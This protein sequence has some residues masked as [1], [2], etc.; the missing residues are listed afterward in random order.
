[1][2][3]HAAG[4]RMPGIAR[5]F[6]VIAALTLWVFA[7]LGCA[8]RHQ[9]LDGR[10]TAA[11]L[12]A[13]AGFSARSITA[14]GFVLKAFARS[15]PDTT[16][17]VYIEG[18]GNS[19]LNR[20]TPSKDPTP[21]LPLAF[22]LAAADPSGNVFYLARPCQF[23]SPRELAAC[24]ARYWTSDRYASDVVEAL[25]LAVDE[26]KRETG[27]KSV[28]LAGFSGGG[29]LAALLAASRNDVEGFMTL[30]GNLDTAA[31]TGLHGLTPLSGS[32]NPA[33][34]AG[35]LRG[36]PQTHI[37]GEKDAVCPRRVAE[38][39]LR[40]LG[41]DSSARLV[42]EPGL[43]HADEAWAARWPQLLR[44]YAPWRAD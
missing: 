8:G 37:V 1:M 41:P 6:A 20:V 16:L 26:A 27:A 21:K 28:R 12:A 7:S 29:T 25:S 17:T 23:L 19:W 38:S 14:G 32:L 11:A 33:D 13:T 42:V 43:G 24:P 2:K 44:D 10:E 3:I 34:E 22:M 39:Y 35:Y 30:G 40:R 36:V 15:S 4:G 18:D 31:W 5:K 9:R